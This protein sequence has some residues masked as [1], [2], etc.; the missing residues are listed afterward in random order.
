MSTESTSESVGA[1]DRS[2]D[3]LLDALAD[4]RRRYVL[5][6]LRE[7]E[8][9]VRPDE[10]A[11]AVVARERERTAETQVPT[12]ENVAISLHHRHLPKLE[13]VGLTERTADGIALTERGASAAVQFFAASSER[14]DE[15]N[16]V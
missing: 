12:R 8:N 16:S 13:R 5:T 14:P 15:S 1:I 11:D 4:D 10:L 7:S 2:V 3:S 9:A 6:H